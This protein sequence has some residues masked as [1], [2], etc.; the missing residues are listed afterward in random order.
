MRTLNKSHVWQASEKPHI[1]TFLKPLLEDLQKLYSTGIEIEIDRTTVTCKAMLIVATME[2]QFISAVL[3]VTKYIGECFSAYCMYQGLEKIT[4]TYFLIRA[5]LQY[6]EP[7]K[8]YKGM[9]KSKYV[10][11][12]LEKVL[13]LFSKFQIKQKHCD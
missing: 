2:L 9:E 5:V 11:V 7:V 10:R 8:R 3:N 6:L 13:K 4:A 12:S 1:T